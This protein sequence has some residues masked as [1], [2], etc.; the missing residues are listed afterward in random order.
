MPDTCGIFNILGILF[1]G[2]LAICGVG[3]LVP[4][5]CYGLLGKDRVVDVWSNHPVIIDLRNNIPDTISGICS[6][7]IFQSRC[8]GYCLAEN[9]HSSGN[10]SGSFWFCQASDELGIFPSSRLKV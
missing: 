3:A 9:Y 5:L 10:F 6:R 1:T 2:H 7:C 8:L 4:E